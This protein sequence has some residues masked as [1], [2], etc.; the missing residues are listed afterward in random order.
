TEPNKGVMNF[1]IQGQKCRVVISATPPL[2]YQQNILTVDLLKNNRALNTDT[3][4]WTSTESV[5]TK[6]KTIEA[7]SGPG[8]YQVNIYV[9]KLG[10]WHVNV[11]DYY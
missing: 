5:T 11:Y 9:T 3:I 8:N 10:N 1:H 4:S 6:E 7:S 2:D